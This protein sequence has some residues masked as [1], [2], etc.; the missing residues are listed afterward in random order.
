MIAML[1]NLILLPALLLSLEKII[2]YEAFNEPLIDTY[3]EEVDI[4]LSKLK[5]RKNK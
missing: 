3:D 1:A 5:I 4:E 2:N